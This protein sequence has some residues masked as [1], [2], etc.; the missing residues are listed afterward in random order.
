MSEIASSLGRSNKIC[1]FNPL[2]SDVNKKGHPYLNKP[3]VESCRFI[4][5]CMTFLLTGGIKGLILDAS[6][7]V[8]S[9]EANSYFST[10]NE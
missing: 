4:E 10:Q 8:N 3:T 2:I 1:I 9:W 5:V 6:L 7:M